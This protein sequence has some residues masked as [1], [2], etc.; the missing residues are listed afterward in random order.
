MT[1]SKRD[2]FKDLRFQL[3]FSFAVIFG[4]MALGTTGYM[5]IEGWDFLDSL[6]MTVI[7]LASVGYGETRPLDTPGRIFTIVLILMGVAALGNLVNQL[8]RGFAEGYFQ[9]GLQR[10]R[11]FQMLSKIENH[12][13]VCGYGRIGQQVCQDFVAEGAAFVILEKDLDLVR[14]AEQDGFLALPG[15]A[16]SD[17]MLLEAG[18]VRARCVL[19]ALPSDAENLFVVLSAKILNPKILTIARA[20]SD[21]GALKL[22]RVGADKVVSPYVTGAKRMAALAL[23]P[24]IIDLMEIVSI[25]GSQAYI[26]ELLL[27]KVTQESTCPY[28]YKSL[29]DAE[30]RSKSGALVLAIRRDSGA[31]VSNPTADTLLE[32]G[33]LLVCMGTGEQLRKLAQIILPTNSI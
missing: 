24:Q 8:A 22:A 19:T 11:R 21:E 4:V 15:D 26:E 27:P 28:L 33:D 23:R 30:L 18:V 12:F 32:P 29:K 20:S 31:F 1:D 9:E 10:R 6:F 2:K 5:A 3:R 14:K 7:T 13:I 25:G 17:E 16:S